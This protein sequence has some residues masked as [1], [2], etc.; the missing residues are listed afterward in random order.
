MS[1]LAPCDKNLMLSYIILYYYLNKYTNCGKTRLLYNLIN[2]F[3]VGSEAMLRFCVTE[4]GTN[5]VA[6]TLDFTCLS[7][8]YATN[9]NYE[10]LSKSLVPCIQSARLSLQSSKLAPPAPSP[11]SEFCLP[12][13]PPVPG[14]RGAHSGTISYNPSSA[15]PVA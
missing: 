5:F 13:P 3:R 7:K 14:V 2:D 1:T 8:F 9:R 4:A 10:I 11:A 12:P 6:D 15:E